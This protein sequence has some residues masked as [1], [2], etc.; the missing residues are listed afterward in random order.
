ME[1]TSHRQ[2]FS[3]A[4][5][6]ERLE[7]VLDREHRALL[8]GDAKAVAALTAEKEQI[9][10][11]LQR[12][13]AEIGD[14]EN[15]SEEIKRLAARVKESANL[16]HLLLKQMYQHYNGMLELF[17]RIGGKSRTYGKNG[18]ISIDVSPEKG[19]EILA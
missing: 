11:S 12:A 16:N 4:E 18:M 5:N 2:T 3:F 19:G 1:Q 7:S 15:L 10:E 8:A 6:L 9:S 17:M 13:R 14:T